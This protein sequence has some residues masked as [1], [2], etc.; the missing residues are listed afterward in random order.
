MPSSTP[1][2]DWLRTDWPVCVRSDCTLHYTAENPLY[3]ITLPVDQTLN[4][5]HIC[6]LFGCLLKIYDDTDDDLS[7]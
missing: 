6:H 5:V 4:Y 1:L 3:D 2:A 7:F